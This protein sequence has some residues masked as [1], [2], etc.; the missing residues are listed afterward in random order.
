KTLFAALVALMAGSARGQQPAE[1]EEPFVEP[2]RRFE[3]GMLFDVRLAFTDDT[4]GFMERGLGKLRYG[5]TSDGDKQVLARLAQLSLVS[6][7]RLSERVGAHLHV[8][9]DAEPDRGNGRERTDLI[10]AYL[11]YGFG[12]GG[13]NEVRGKAGLFFP[14]I[15]LEHPGEAWTTFYTITPSILNGW[16]GEEIRSLGIETSFVRA[17]LE[18]EVSFTGAGFGWN[19]PSAS[20]LAYRGWASNDRQAGYADRVPL[21]PLSSIGEG[22]IFA[23]QAPWAEPVREVDDR[24]GFYAAASWDNYQRFLVNAIYYDNRARPVAFDSEQ[25]GWRTRFYEAGFLYTFSDG[26]SGPELLFQALSGDTWMGGQGAGQPKVTFDF[27]SAYLLLTVP[28]GRQRL[29]FRYDWFDMADRDEFRGVND[30]DEN[31]YGMTLAYL[32]RTTERQR[33]AFELLGVRS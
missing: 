19:D 13:R 17:G 12:V 23:A 24:A 22:G 32:L 14:V 3:L 9:F 21:P 8:N 30:N 2:T 27:R 28:F 10:E 26:T 15:S 1:E 5:G 20:L 33:L 6:E 29:S 18:N 7:L 31:G 11:R 25:Y 16:I 4:L